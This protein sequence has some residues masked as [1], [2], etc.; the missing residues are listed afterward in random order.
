MTA[1]SG[2]TRSF[3]ALVLSRATVGAAESG[4]P[5]T[6][7]SLLSD[8]FSP[9]RRPLALGVFYTA[10]VVGL[11]GGSLLGAAVGAAYGWRAA[12]FA[13]AAPGLLLA[14]LALLSLREPPR[15]AFGREGHAAI[16]PNARAVA[17]TLVRSRRL[18]ACV[19]AL[20][21]ASVTLGASY[22]FPAFLIRSL[23]LSLRQAGPVA[24]LVVGV[25]GG[26]GALAGGLISQRLGG[27]G[28]NR[29]IGLCSVALITAVP[30]GVCGVL[31]SAPAAVCAGIAIWSFFNSGYIG[32][33]YAVC[34]ATTPASKRGTVTAPVVVLS[35]VLG[36]GLGPQVVGL[37]SDG[38]SRAGEPNGL[39]RALACILSA[40]ALA[41][42]LLLAARH[43]PDRAAVDV[44]VA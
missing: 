16:R 9:R 1:L 30:F 19:G 11:V 31:A 23:H 3:P 39:G 18:G 37:L 5:S 7:L 15:G 17:I 36:A 44:V 27:T 13:A 28:S 32:P 43:R 12:L 41:G 20:V 14:A 22:W 38:F 29:L 2:F 21:L 6:M 33:A 40:G 24:A 10:P 42:P 35:N 26:V 25:P 8:T 34:L 4:A